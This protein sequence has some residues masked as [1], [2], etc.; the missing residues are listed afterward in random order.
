MD[1]ALARSRGIGKSPNLTL[2]SKAVARIEEVEECDDD[3]EDYEDTYKGSHKF[4][5]LAMHGYWKRWEAHKAGAPRP[6]RNKNYKKKGE[7]PMTCYNCGSA[8]HFVKECP[9][10]PRE[11]KEGKLVCKDK[12]KSPKNINFARRVP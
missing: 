1:D 10:E 4:I 3:E 9:F 6:S 11:E 2:K 8:N 5:A 12:T 7:R